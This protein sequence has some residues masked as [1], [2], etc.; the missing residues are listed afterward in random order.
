MKI[1][2]CCECTVNGVPYKDLNNG[3]KIIAG[4]KII[5]ALQKLYLVSAPIFI[6]NAEAISEGN[7]PEMDNQMIL[8]VVSNDKK[9]KTEV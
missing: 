4:L 2:E 3:H 1:K 9:I 6:D 5:K 8:L 7:M